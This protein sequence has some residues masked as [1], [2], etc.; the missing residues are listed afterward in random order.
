MKKVLRD[1][2]RLIVLAMALTSVPVGVVSCNDDAGDDV[3]DAA[4]DA[5]D[6]VDDAA[7]DVEDAVDDATD[8]MGD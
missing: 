1:W 8:E 5:G 7:D 2:I 6:A 3:E 4:D